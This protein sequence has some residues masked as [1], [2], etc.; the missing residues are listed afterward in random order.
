LAKFKDNDAFNIFERIY[1]STQRFPHFLLYPNNQPGTND[2]TDQANVATCYIGNYKNLPTGTTYNDFVK[3]IDQFVKY[4]K[5]GCDEA[6]AR[7]FYSDDPTVLALF[8]GLSAQMA[9]LSLTGE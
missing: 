1:D 4:K 3:V 9:S 8:G 2:T 7:E 6:L 5:A